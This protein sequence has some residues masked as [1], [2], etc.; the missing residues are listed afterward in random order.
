MKKH[1][2][3]LMGLLAVCTL[4][5]TAQDKDASLDYYRQETGDYAGIYN[6]QIENLYHS[7]FYTN[8]PYYKSNDFTTGTLLY[9]QTEFREVRLRL[10][11]FRDQL[12]ILSPEKQ[13]GIILNPARVEKVFMHNHTLVWLSGETNQIAA[14]YY[15]L[16]TETPSMRLLKKE[17]C[18]E[19][20]RK[21]IYRFIF[22]EEYY[23]EL[24]GKYYS[25]NN[26]NSFHKLFPEYKKQINQFA[27][28]QRL[29][30]KGGKEQ[31]FIALAEYC[32]QLTTK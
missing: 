17:R 10:D 2:L 4:S 1:V 18:T 31:S 11:I 29:N 5:V 25:L 16:L 32:Y 12:V 3:T 8:R 9:N 7:A 22:K 23:L 13:Y 26:K 14:G 15:A 6:G 19:D 30:F 21:E 24:N 27:K 20:R 28:E